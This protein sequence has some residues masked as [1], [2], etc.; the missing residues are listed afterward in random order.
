VKWDFS[1]AWQQ[2]LPEALPDATNH[3]NHCR[4]E[5][6][7]SQVPYHQASGGYIAESNKFGKCH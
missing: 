2:F 5:S 6:N 3:S 4:Q 7:Q 1:D